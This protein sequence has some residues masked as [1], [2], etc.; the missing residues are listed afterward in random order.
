MD[1]VR[2]SNQFK[3]FAISNIKQINKCFYCILFLDLGPQ[4]NLQPLDS[5]E[6]NVFK[7]KGLH[8]IHLNINN[9]PKIDELQYIAKSSCTAAIEISESKIDESFLQSEIQINNCDLLC[10]DINRNNRDIASYISCDISYISRQKYPDKIKNIFFEFLLLKSKLTVIVIIYHSPIQNNLL[11][12]LNKSFPS[13]NKDAKETYI[14]GIIK[15]NMYENN[16]YMVHK[17]NTVCA[18]F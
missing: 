11:E 2:F 9:L 15:I 1:S 13:S 17:N 12:V 5:N 16:K 6:L 7:S 8:L 4:N 18:K 14:P 3:V 10:W